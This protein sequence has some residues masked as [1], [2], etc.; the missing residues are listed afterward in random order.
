MSIGA[1]SYG[2]VAE[3]EALVS[4][5]TDDGVFTAATRPTLTQ[6][7]KFIDRVS[8]LVNVLL[9]EQGFDIPVSQADAKLTLDDFVVAQVVQVCHGS[10]GAGNFAPGSR[11]LRSG[12]PFMLIT[13]EAA[14]FIEA[15]ADGLELLGATR[16][17]H[18]TDGLDCRRTDD[19]GDEIHPMFQRKM[20]GH[21]VLDWDA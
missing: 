8:A 12:T 18:A 11:A 5:Y 15:H 10:N 3:V 14:E 4:R 2:S 1:N 13:R 6:V 7:E 21:R 19:A 17:R 16:T 20:M 9:A